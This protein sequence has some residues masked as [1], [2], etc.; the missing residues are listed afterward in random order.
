MLQLAVWLLPLS[1]AFAASTWVEHAERGSRDFKHLDL[2]SATKAYTEAIQAAKLEHSAPDVIADLFLNLCACQTKS[3]NFDEAENSLGKAVALLPGLTHGEEGIQL[4]VLRRKSELE[5]ARE[6]W[7]EAEKTQTKLL[8]KASSY[9]GANSKYAIEEME[10]LCL[11]Q[12]SSGNQKGEVETRRRMHKALIAQGTNPKGQQMME[13]NIWLALRLIDAKLID[14]AQSLL[15]ESF[16]NAVESKSVAAELECSALFFRCALIKGDRVGQDKWRKHVFELCEVSTDD[17]KLLYAQIQTLGQMLNGYHYAEVFSEETEVL[18][19]KAL[20]LTEKSRSKL[21]PYQ[22]YLCRSQ[23]VW[24]AVEILCK[25]GNLAEAIKISSQPLPSKIFSSGWDFLVVDFTYSTLANEFKNRGD[26][27][28][29]IKQVDILLDAYK[30]N[31][32]DWGKT[33]PILKWQNIR[34]DLVRRQNAQ[35]SQ[36]QAGK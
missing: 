7:S 23:A 31:P 1:G 34:A 27:K 19:R 13:K 20:R 29:A 2:H 35:A 12:F 14:Q 11:Y 18:A 15:T 5:A 32:L 21:S 4:R 3:K 22:Y 6:S 8:N 24:Y 10:K 33:D 36:S 16:A 9:F 30:R 25:R 17:A 26:Y 28:S